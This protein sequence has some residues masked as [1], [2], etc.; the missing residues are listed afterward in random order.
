MGAQLIAR[1]LMRSNHPLT[2]FIS[3]GALIPSSQANDGQRPALYPKYLAASA[4]IEYTIKSGTSNIADPVWLIGAQKAVP[5]GLRNQR[6]RDGGCSKHLSCRSPMIFRFPKPSFETVPKA[7]A[8]VPAG[9]RVYVIGDIHGRL[10]LLDCL[11]YKISDDLRQ[12]RFDEAVTIFLGDYIDRGP[13]SAGVTE[14][15]SAG[16]LPTR[17]VALRG[18]H[19]ATLLSFLEDARVLADWRRYGGLET[20]VSYGVDVKKVMRGQGY[21]AALRFLRRNLPP[22]HLAFF[23]QTR[24]SSSI[25]DY[26]F[27]HAGVRPGAALGHQNERDLLWIRDEFNLYHGTFEKIIVHGHTPVEEPQVLPNRIC[28]DTG[29]YATGVLTC[30]VLEGANRRFIS[31]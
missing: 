18:N 21:D 24:L 2:E 26:F 3:R 7:T 20:L 27:C 13:H 29:A 16:D 17:I 5:A 11:A 31:T 28:I 22:R 6:R 30:L 8:S 23:E 10:D 4:M 15:L 1:K 14:R 19:E 25:G 12:G 9:L